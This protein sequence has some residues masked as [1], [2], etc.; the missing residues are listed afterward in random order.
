MNAEECKEAI[1]NVAL[2]IK[3]DSIKNVVLNTISKIPEYFY[4][5][6][7][8]SSGKYHPEDELGSDGLVRHTLKCIKVIDILGRRFDFTQYQFDLVTASLLL[9]DCCKN[10]FENSGHTEHAHP[11]Y[12]A[13]LVRE[14]NPKSFVAWRIASLIKTHMGKWTKVAYS[15]IKLPKPKTK[16][17]KFVHECDFVASRKEITINID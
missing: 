15:P 9:H 4:T 5:V 7:S 6:P 3:T 16:L 17:Q 12:A 14:A 13:R 1:L 11:L 2:N 8:S 10:G